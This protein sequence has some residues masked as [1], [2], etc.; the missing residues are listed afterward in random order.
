MEQFFMNKILINHMLFKILIN[1]IL[2]IKK[3]N[4]FV[5]RRSKKKKNFYEEKNNRKL[6]FLHLGA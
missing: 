5:K 2:F 4:D 6:T 3:P 1:H